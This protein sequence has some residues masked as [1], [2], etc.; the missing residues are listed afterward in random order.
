[1]RSP[2]DF[3]TTS[4]DHRAKDLGDTQ[5]RHRPSAFWQRHGLKVLGG[6]MMIL[7]STVVT[8]QVAC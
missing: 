7:F 3:E 8:A 1:M 4:D 5:R 2:D 6:I